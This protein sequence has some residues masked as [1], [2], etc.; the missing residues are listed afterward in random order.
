M[1]RLIGCATAKQRDSHLILWLILPA[2]TKYVVHHTQL[3]KELQCCLR[4]VGRPLQP[5]ESPICQ[6][7]FYSVLRVVVVP[8]K[9]TVANVDCAAW[10]H[11]I[12][13]AFHCLWPLDRHVHGLVFLP[14]GTIAYVNFFEFHETTTSVLPKVLGIFEKNAAE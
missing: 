14:T 4:R 13:W 6:H 7:I 9:A 10:L 1:A 11:R 8:R 2:Q 3:V 12:V 5:G